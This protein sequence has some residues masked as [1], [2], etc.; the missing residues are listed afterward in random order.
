[1]NANDLIGSVGDRMSNPVSYRTGS[2]N[3]VP[4]SYFILRQDAAVVSSEV[5]LK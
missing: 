3:L 4:L 1:M 2:R 5:F